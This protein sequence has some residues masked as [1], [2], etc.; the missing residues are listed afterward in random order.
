MRV[1][2][3]GYEEGY[4][5]SS[6]EQLSVVKTHLNPGV[7]EWQGR[8][9]NPHDMLDHAGTVDTLVLRRVSNR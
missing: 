5:D 7:H 4:D 8:H 9:G 2:V 1:V 3:I 6:P